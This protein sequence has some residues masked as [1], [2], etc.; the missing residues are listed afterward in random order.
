VEP[1]LEGGGDPEVAAPAAQPPEQL[2]LGLGVDPQPLA[3]GGDQVDRAQVVDGQAEPAHGVPEAAAQGQPADAGV[4]DDPGRGGQPEPLG[5]AVQLAQQ[6]SAGGAGRA[7]LRVDPD[8]LHRRQVD[9][10]P[11][12]DDR[13]AG[14]GVPAAA[15]RDP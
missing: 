2:R 5:G 6:D 12:V 4:A 15:D 11:T 13:V 9:H 14:H 8:G 1:V 10:Q 7:A 3:V